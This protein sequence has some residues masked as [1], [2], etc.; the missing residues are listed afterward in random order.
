MEKEV[1]FEL[2]EWA[3]RDTLPIGFTEWLKDLVKEQEIELGKGYSRI[4]EDLG[5]P[6]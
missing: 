5:V 2:K 3:S 6:S 1:D 4:A